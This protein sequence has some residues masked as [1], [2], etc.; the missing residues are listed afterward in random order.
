MGSER[1]IGGNLKAKG[2][3]ESWAGFLIVSPMASSRM[4]LSLMLSLMLAVGGCSGAKKTEVVD[5]LSSMRTYDPEAKNA[6]VSV[7]KPYVIMV[8]IDGYRW[9]YTKKFAPPHISR[10]HKE[11]VAAE[12]LIPVYPTKTFPNHYS[13]VTGLYANKHGIV[14]NEFYSPEREA[15]YSLPDRKAVEDG[16]WYQGEPLWIAVQKQG[17]LTASFFWVGS[18]ASIQGRHPN[19]YYRYNEVI[20]NARRVEQVLEWLRLPAERRPHFITLYFSDVDT[21]GHRYGPESEQVKEAVLKIDEMIGRL[22]EG[23]AASG[24]PVNVIV[25]SDHGME[26]IDPDKILILDEKP[27]AAGWLEK[28]RV[29][30]RGPQMNLYLKK[31]EDPK[32]IRAT[33]KVLERGARHYRVL[34]GPAL[35]RLN[36]DGNPRTGDLVIEPDAPYSV[37]VKANPPSSK[38]GNHG[39]DGRKFKSMHGIFYATGPAF[40]ENTKLASFELVHVYPLV[41]KVLGLSVPTPIDGRLEPVAKALRTDV[42]SGPGNRRDSRK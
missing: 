26:A 27:E 41:M 34:S 9:D 1:A 28:F 12:S 40:K 11:G 3:G 15:T 36:Y 21:A 33:K 20:P 37:G 14:S 5:D 39:W 10:L 38:G 17:L 13:L 31:G 25:V 4:V 6:A 30:G 19:Y 2:F 23:V 16:S 35:K 29:I 7:N 18:E 32:A 22:R 8:S 42:T 24:L